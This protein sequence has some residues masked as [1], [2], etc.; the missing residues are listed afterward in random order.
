MGGKE[1][2]TSQLARGEFCYVG[3]KAELYRIA[4]LVLNNDDIGLP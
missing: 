3:V 4:S 1:A 2:L